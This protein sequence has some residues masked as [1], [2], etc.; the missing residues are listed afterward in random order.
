[1][2]N[3]Y[4]KKVFFHLHPNL[5]MLKNALQ[6]KVKLSN[7]AVSW[8]LHSVALMEEL[9]LHRQLMHAAQLEVSIE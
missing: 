2:L 3:F 9:I 7:Q 1:M 4:Q 6:S 8:V 5:T